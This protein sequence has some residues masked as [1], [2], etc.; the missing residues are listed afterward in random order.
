[1][2]HTYVLPGGHIGVNI[3]FVLSGFLITT[4][5]L[6]EFEGT[7]RVSLRRFYIRRALRLLPALYVV[8]AVFTVYE[9]VRRHSVDST[10]TSLPAVLLYV[11]NWV[12]V[13]KGVDSLGLWGH[14]WSLSIEEQFYLIWPVVLVAATRRLRGAIAGVALFVVIASPVWRAVLGADGSSA[15]RFRGTDVNLDGLMVGCLLAVVLLRPSRSLEVAARWLWAPAAAFLVW[16][17]TLTSG[18]GAF[19]HTAVCVAAGVVLARVV[20]QPAGR[21][22]I[23]LSWAPLAAAGRISYGLYLWHLPVTLALTG[24][25]ANKWVLTLAVTAVTVP[26]AV[27]S[28]LLI[29]S[30]AL[31][32]KR[33]F[34]PLHPDAASVSPPRL[35]LKVRAGS[36]LRRLRIPSPSTSAEADPAGEA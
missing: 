21:L 29:E 33:H 31:R 20:T 27:C 2:V 7:G 25:I 30:P 19:D 10:I 22:S 32:M 16:R 9:L 15:A 23:A 35:A 6:R 8:L 12:Q 18:L 36:V 26:A 34:E 11:G 5:L 14:T 4:I 1:L 17:M 28:W 24:H 13:A 3:F